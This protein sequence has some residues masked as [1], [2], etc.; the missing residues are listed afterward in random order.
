MKRKS[1]FWFRI[2]EWLNRNGHILLGIIVGLS[3]GIG[4]PSVCIH[5]QTYT[6]SNYKNMIAIAK[7]FASREQYDEALDILWDIRFEYDPADVCYKNI[8]ETNELYTHYTDG[9]R[10]MDLQ[11]Y[12]KA[13]LEFSKCLSYKDAQEL[14]D[15]CIIL[16]YGL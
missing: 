9:V 2:H 4:I 5:Y 11:L 15:K 6:I 13:A 3:L 16:N 7:D 1:L 12:S 14:F 8:A 10:L